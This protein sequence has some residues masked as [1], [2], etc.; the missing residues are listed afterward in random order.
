MK[1]IVSWLRERYYL[2]TPVLMFLSFPSFDFFIF[3][4]F[5]FFAWISLAPVFLYIR[6][7]SLKDVYYTAFIAGLL[8]NLFTYQWIGNF[9]PPGSGGYFVILIPLIPCLSV[10]FSLKIFL[11]EYLSRKYEHLRFLIF[12]AIWIIIEWIQS[13]GFL[14]FPLPLW[15]Y[16]QYPCT[17]LLQSA[18]VIGATGIAYIMI[19]FNYLLSELIYAKKEN[20]LNARLACSSQGKRLIGLTVLIVVMIFSG[21][22]RLSRDDK[23]IKKDLRVSIVQTCIDPWENWDRNKMIYLDELIKITDFS[24]RENPDFIIWSESA[25]LETISYD[26]DRK[27]RS[28]FE[29]EL[30][31][32][33][34][35][36]GRPLLTG[37]IGILEDS[38]GFIMRRNP[39]NNAVLVNGFGEV[40]KSYSKINLVPFGEWFPYE[41]WLPVIGDIAVSFGGSKFIPG[42][43]PVLFDLENRRFGALICYEGIFHRLCRGY[44]NMGADFFINITNDNWTDSYAGHMQHFS[45]SVFRAVENGIWY[46]RAG[47][48]GCSAV[49][50]PLGRIVKSIPILKKG[51]L[52]GDIDFSLNRPTFYAAHGDLL[53][54]ASMI[55]IA[56]LMIIF[57]AGKIRQKRAGNG[58]KTQIH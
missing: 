5:P 28:L 7:K 43:E 8:G 52:V 34:K 15:A 48:S 26:Y 37:E 38:S 46:I 24:L 55:F 33:I 30:L 23:P 40:I 49:I 51:Y 32:Y 16:S 58:K 42:A 57:L 54:H 13:I 27:F 47:N 31:D 1:R 17:S 2:L 14:A 11:S 53:L 56:L 20:G 21:F 35:A 19:M 41:K 4:L 39:Q 9:A 44:R 25:T 3:R 18:S 36:R 6:D 10:F 50:D 12:P 29:K 22:I 45:A